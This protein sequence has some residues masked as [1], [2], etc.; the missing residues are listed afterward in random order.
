MLMLFILTQRTTVNRSCRYPSAF[1]FPLASDRLCFSLCFAAVCTS[2]EAG[3]HL[4]H[5]R[6]RS[7]LTETNKREKLTNS[8]ASDCVI[9][10][11]IPP[12]EKGKGKGKGKS[13]TRSVTTTA[14]N[15]TDSEI[16]SRRRFLQV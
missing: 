1:L 10:D 8:S 15:T 6:R 11:E 9:V 5:S 16:S 13:S 3:H 7:S 14:S 12:K 2:P 4:D